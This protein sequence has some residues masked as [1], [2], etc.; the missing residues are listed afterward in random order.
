VVADEGADIGDPVDYRKPA[1]LRET[2]RE[3]QANKESRDEEDR[4]TKHGK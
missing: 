1:V 4:D 2:E 3:K